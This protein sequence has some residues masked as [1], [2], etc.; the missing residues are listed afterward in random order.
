MYHNSG[1]IPR[2]FAQERN[3]ARA[4]IGPSLA[5]C[6]PS[7]AFCDALALFPPTHVDPPRWGYTS[8]PGRITVPTGPPVAPP[9]NTPH[10]PAY[11][12]VTDV[13][14]ASG[15]GDAP[16]T[17]CDDEHRR[18]CPKSRACPFWGTS[19]RVITQTFLL[20]ENG[21]GIWP[22]LRYISDF[23]QHLITILACITTQASRKIPR[24]FAQER[25]D[26]RTARSQ[27]Y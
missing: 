12:Y 15:H 20:G 25:H 6:R 13:T 26:A 14:D 21:L 2:P 1:Q 3:D 23:H 22:M 18:E 5:F 24:P 9:T 8:G 4:Q 16:R 19:S 10:R 11:C 27:H 7:L 17:R